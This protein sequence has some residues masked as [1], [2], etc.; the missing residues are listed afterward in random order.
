MDG[1]RRADDEPLVLSEFRDPHT[2]VLTLNR[3]GELFC[4]VR[5]ASSAAKLTTAFARR[6]LIA[7]H[8]V[9]WILPRFSPLRVA[10]R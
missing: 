3:P 5:F 4:D 8:G 9:A 1:S 10:S 7:E 2:R 6:G